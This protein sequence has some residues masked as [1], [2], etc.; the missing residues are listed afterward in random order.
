MARSHKKSPRS[1]FVVIPLGTRESHGSARPVPSAE[2]TTVTNAATL[3]L[4]LRLRFTIDLEVE[5]VE[6]RDAI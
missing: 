6:E 5:T 3:E 1:S 2:T 4:V